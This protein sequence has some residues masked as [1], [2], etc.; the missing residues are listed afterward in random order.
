MGQLDEISFKLGQLDSKLDSQSS[1]L[2]S[3][4]LDIDQDRAVQTQDRSDLRLKMNGLD[5]RMQGVETAAKQIAG[6][7]DDVNQFNNMK[8]K[9][10]IAIGVAASIIAGAFMFLWWGVQALWPYIKPMLP[11]FFK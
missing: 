4:K 10:G 6:I 8:T 1:T 2:R 7:Q 5:E 9:I 11:S 3:M